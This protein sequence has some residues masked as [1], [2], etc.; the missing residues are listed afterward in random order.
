MIPATPVL[1][2]QNGVVPEIVYAK[3]QPQYIPLPAARFED[4]T[5]ITRW[6]LTWR[7]RFQLLIGGSLWLELLTFN[8]PLQPIRFWTTEPPI[9][10]GPV[11]QEKDK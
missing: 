6:T 10:V 1:P 3:D 2:R 5:V 4:G 9:Q 8:K 7:E 11:A